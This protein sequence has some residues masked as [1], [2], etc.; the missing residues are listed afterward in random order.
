[1][2]TRGLAGFALTS[3]VLAGTAAASSAP[4][5]TATLTPNK[6]GAASALS[7]SVAGPLPSG[8]PTQLVLTAQKGVT[9]DGVKAVTAICTPAQAMANQCPAGSVVGSG[10]AGTNFGVSLGFTLAVGAKQQASDIA[11]VFLIGKVGTTKFALPGRLFMPA[12]GGLELLATGFPQIPFISLTSLQ[13][14]AKG[15]NTATTYTKK[16]ITTGTGKKKKTKIVKVAHKTT[17]SVL[18]NPSTCPS[19]GTWSG[20]V[21]ATYSTGPI[22]LPFT[23]ACTS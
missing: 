2:K 9:S 21:Q 20:T 7:V 18:R 22:N 8:V 3:L 5:V 15:T 23:V 16:K 1:M 6:A 10:S 14:S 13:L 4:T 12:G 19:T 17:Y 11:T